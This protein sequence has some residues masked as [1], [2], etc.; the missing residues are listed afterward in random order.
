MEIIKDKL[1]KEGLKGK[2]EGITMAVTHIKRVPKTLRVQK[3]EESSGPQNKREK[4]ECE[5]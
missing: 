2:R 1:S 3:G 5:E 4:R